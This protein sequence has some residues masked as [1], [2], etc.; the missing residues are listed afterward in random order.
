MVEFS[1]FE[2]TSKEKTGMVGAN[3]IVMVKTGEVIYEVHGGDG[4]SC[5]TPELNYARMQRCLIECKDNAI[6]A[7]RF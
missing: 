1:T 4:L 3:K 7:S 5:R 6:L 2:S